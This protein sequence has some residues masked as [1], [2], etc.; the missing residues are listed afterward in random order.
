MPTKVLATTFEI[1]AHPGKSIKF[2]APQVV[3][4]RPQVA[5]AT[6]SGD[7]ANGGV[8]N[9]KGKEVTAPL[10]FTLN[11]VCGARNGTA[12]L[13]V[14]IPLRPVGLVDFVI[15]KECYP[16]KGTATSIGNFVEGLFIGTAP[17]TS[18]VVQNGITQPKY[19][20]WVD[21]AVDGTA[22]LYLGPETRNITFYV[23][24]DPPRKGATGEVLAG[25]PIASPVAVAH[26]PIA[27]PNVVGDL[28]HGG[29]LTAIDTPMRVNFHCVYEGVTP[30]TLYV[31]LRDPA[32]WHV[33]R[34]TEADEK[35]T[36]T[37]S[38]HAVVG[39]TIAKECGSVRGDAQGDA[40]AAFSVNVDGVDLH[41][42]GSSGLTHISARPDADYDPG[43]DGV[44]SRAVNDG[45]LGGFG[46]DDPE[47]VVF[48]ADAYDYDLLWHNE[49][50]DY[51]WGTGA[52]G[53]EHLALA[54]SHEEDFDFADDLAQSLDKQSDDFFNSIGGDGGGYYGD[55]IRGEPDDLSG[56]VDVASTEARL[57]NPDVV[58]N[59][60]P[61][62]KYK[63]CEVEGED[64]I[65]VGCPVNAVVAR[66]VVSFLVA[67]PLD[68]AQGTVTLGEPFAHSLR[69]AVK[70]R[71]ENA[72]VVVG[73][74]LVPGEA[75]KVEVSFDCLAVGVSSPV[76]VTISYNKFKSASFRF[77][78]VCG[79]SEAV[80]P[81]WS[82][83][84]L[85]L[86]AA[87]SMG[88]ILVPWL[89]RRGYKRYV[90]LE[91]DKE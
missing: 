38:H 17:G 40:L 20:R 28:R 46:G 91:S 75:A 2:S 48:D 11:Y 4:F 65:D 85:I 13:H 64:D 29:V 58:V 56:L 22:R 45:G 39:L 76:V 33:G 37:R 55:E 8:L 82:T 53:R 15:E 19:R 43:G 77:T 68:S 54:G 26:L 12:V 18:D 61:T 70:A 79:Y 88:L 71:V 50:Y 89:G 1:D 69:H 35:G 47:G 57:A 25:R 84:T 5:R 14:A 24:S 90:K 7:A 87:A 59:G 6:I 31:P 67:P 62:G 81:G 78:K 44:A 80:A 21:G 10:R 41:G 30:I 83:F 74:Q 32:L 49:P 72:D 60:I 86:V 36:A 52:A 73:R 51:E 3:S 27:N 23:R 34:G 16:V 42:D 9:S 66:E 63:L